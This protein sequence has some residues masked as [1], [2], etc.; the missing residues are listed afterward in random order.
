MNT[1]IVRPHPQEREK[2]I[3][4]WSDLLTSR[5]TEGTQRGFTLVELLVVIA[6][7]AIL[8]GLVLPALGRAKESGRSSACLSNLHQIGIALQLYVSD[9]QNKLPTMFDW[10]TNS[11]ANTNGPPINVVLATQS[12]SSNI[13]RCPS[14]NQNLFALTGS[15]YSWNSLLNGEDADNLHAMGMNFANHEIPLVY[16]KANFHQPL[17]AARAVNY[18]Y[19]DQH[20]KNLLQIQGTIQQ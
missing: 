7:I 4:R 2:R 15:S 12:G 16:D 11:A 6:V 5:V 9:G 1:L 10:A 8:A 3:P 20:I 14:D 19:A 18:L 17:G 13:F